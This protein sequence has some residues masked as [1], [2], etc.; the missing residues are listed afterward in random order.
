MI[1]ILH[2]FYFS[3]KIFNVTI[4]QYYRSWNENMWSLQPLPWLWWV[5]TFDSPHMELN[6]FLTF[7]F[8]QFSNKFILMLCWI[9]KLRQ[10]LS[11]EWEEWFSSF[12]VIKKEDLSFVLL[13]FLFHGTNQ[14][15]IFQTMKL[16][17]FL[18]WRKLL[19][20]REGKQ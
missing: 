15:L 3:Q 7:R 5:F 1:Q 10:L 6:F 19:L 11:E 12:D 18:K 4:F 2:Q 14:S 13:Q 17:S 9:I 8:L 16:H 20:R